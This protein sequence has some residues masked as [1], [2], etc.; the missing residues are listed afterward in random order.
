MVS[1]QIRERKLASPRIIGGSGDRFFDEACLSA[2]KGVD[3][4]LPELPFA[5]LDRL[6]GDARV[7]ISC[8]LLKD[9]PSLLDGR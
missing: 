8:N 2:V 1:A 5:A 9:V 3:G 7:R 4:G 6:E